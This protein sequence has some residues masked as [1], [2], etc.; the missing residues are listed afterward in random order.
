M[1]CLTAL[2]D[3]PRLGKAFALALSP[4]DTEQT[5]GF[6]TPQAELDSGECHGGDPKSFLMHLA[7]AL[8]PA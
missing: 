8:Q 1:A 4:K 2:P 6:T 7:S 5:V 3:P